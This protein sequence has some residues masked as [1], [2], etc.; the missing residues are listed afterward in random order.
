MS[1][2]KEGTG[3]GLSITQS[4]IRMLGGQIWV[5]S[6]PAKGSTFFFEIPDIVIKDTEETEDKKYVWKDK[7]IL[8][9]E[10]DIED[11]IALEEIL[12]NRIKIHFLNSPEQALEFCSNQKQIDVCMISWSEDQNPELIH[13][14]LEMM[15]SHPVI[16]MVN[17]GF[18]VKE[19]KTVQ[20]YF[21]E[22]ISKSFKK[23]QIL[24]LL[25]KHLG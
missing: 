6:T 2:K 3:L 16:A 8:I 20:K 15:P 23:E 18:K 19:N 5:E 9:I 4:L 17:K 24:S 25:E 13:N 22:V 7:Q 12:K 11:Y 21:S 14:I 10:D 1:I